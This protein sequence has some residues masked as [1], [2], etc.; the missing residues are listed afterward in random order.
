[1]KFTAT[2]FL[3]LLLAITASAQNLWLNDYE[4][5][6]GNS[7]IGLTLVSKDVSGFER[8]SDVACSYFYV[9]QLKDIKMKC[10]IGIDGSF[11]FNELD[12]QGNVRAVF[13]GKFVKNEQDLAEGSW[14]RSGRTRPL[15]FRMRMAQGVSSE[16]GNRYAQIDAADPA[17]FET[18]VRDFRTAVM[19]TD[20]QKVVSQIK[21]PIRVA[22][23]GKTVKVK[24]KTAMLTFYDR[25]FTKEFAADLEKTVPHNM[26]CKFSGA[27]LGNGIV[28]FWGDGKVIAINN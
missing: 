25:V 2:L 26:F 20:K 17:K 11:T 9:S 4:G 3:G 27:M 16:N 12:E 14:T 19:K 13:R 5:T 7:K 1:M 22:V 8:G 21:Y 6:V 28:W 24:N 18:A 15:P 10:S 23:N